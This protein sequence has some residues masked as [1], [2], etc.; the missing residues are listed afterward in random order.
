MPRK[1]EPTVTVAVAW[2]DPSVA[3][4]VTFAARSGAI[5]RPDVMAPAVAVQV[6]PGG[7]AMA[8]PNW[9]NP[10]AANCCTTSGAM[11]MWFGVMESVARTGLSFTATLL[12]AASPP[13]PVTLTVN[14]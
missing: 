9:S 14:L 4:T 3:V 2:T 6:S 5:S 13:G 1:V 12:L 11:A 8:R 10:S 7:R